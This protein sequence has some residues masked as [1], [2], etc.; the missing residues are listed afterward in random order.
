MHVTSEEETGKRIE[1]PSRKSKRTSLLLTVLSFAIGGVL[2]IMVSRYA[3]P[4][5]ELLVGVVLAGIAGCIVG[6]WLGRACKRESKAERL[7][8]LAM[9]EENQGKKRKLMG[10]IVSKYPDTEWVDKVLDERIE[11]EIVEAGQGSTKTSEKK[12]ST[13]ILSENKGEIN[14]WKEAQRLKDEGL[15]IVWKEA[16]RLR[17]EGLSIRAIAK[18]LGVAKSTI[19]DRTVPSSRPSYTSPRMRTKRPLK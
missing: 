12:V 11:N 8:M 19:H 1:R 13:G 7:F 10:K 6:F 5:A 15:S 2:G 14:V 16:Q 17:D 4:S 18:R 9:Q 3:K